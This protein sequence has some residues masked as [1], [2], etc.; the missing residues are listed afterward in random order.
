MTLEEAKKEIIKRHHE[1]AE[2]Y[3]REYDLLAYGEFKGLGFA[4]E[5]LTQVS[6]VSNHFMLSLEEAKKKVS[7]DGIC[8]AFSPSDYKAGWTDAM[9]KAAEMMEKYIEPVEIKEES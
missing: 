1:K 5:L 8:D 3:R 6:A 4:L 2:E 7:E 9:N